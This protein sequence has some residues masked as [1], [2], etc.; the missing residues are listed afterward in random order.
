MQKN[1]VENSK[2]IITFYESV[3][4][5]KTNQNWRAKI[6]E[7]FVLS[8][9]WKLAIRFSFAFYFLCF[10]LLIAIAFEISEMASLWS[11]QNEL[12]EWYLWWCTCNATYIS[13]YA[14]IIKTTMQKE[15]K[16]ESKRES[17]VAKWILLE[18]NSKPQN[19]D[20]NR[21]QKHCKI[22]IDWECK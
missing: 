15:T 13:A 4:T 18:N 6:D 21:M 14:Q 16:N 2:R 20:K 22:W 7:I 19:N 9:W 10:H 12:I 1:E 17:L 3:A 11:T 8:Q 5:K